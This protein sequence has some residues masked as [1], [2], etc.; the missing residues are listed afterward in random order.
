MTPEQTGKAYDQIAHRW[1][2]P[3]FDSRNGI[4]AHVRALDLVRHGQ[5][6]LDV[7][8][9]CNGRFFDLLIERGLQPEGIDVSREM[10][11]LARERYPDIPIQRADICRFELT[12]NYDFITAWDSI[13]HVPFSSQRQVITKLLDA[14]TGGG[15]LIFS[16]GGLESEDEITDDY[17]G[18]TLYYATL[19]VSGV[20]HLVEERGCQVIALE[21]DQEPESH[22]YLI[23][24]KP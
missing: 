16:F 8:C 5:H 21:L 19:G 15:V 23:A 24:R 7:G 22:A 1:C 14:L 12:K 18:P 3:G 10:V 17:M 4:T 2:A 13:W 20:R 11:R 6:A 9:G